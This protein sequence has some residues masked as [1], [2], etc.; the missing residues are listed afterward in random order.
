MTDF[1]SHQKRSTRTFSDFSF[2]LPRVEKVDP[3]FPPREQCSLLLSMSLPAIILLIYGRSILVCR[4]V[5]R[6]SS[7]LPP[8]SAIFM[9]LISS[10]PP[11]PGDCSW[12]R[13]LLLA[14][15]LWTTQSEFFSLLIHCAAK[16]HKITHTGVGSRLVSNQRPSE[17][18]ETGLQ[19]GCLLFAYALQSFCRYEQT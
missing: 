14:S 5:L 10:P 3:L 16:T 15:F 1:T 18:E 11:P 6:I 4:S 9:R 7:E 2:P 19:R 8:P 13:S 17:P 12:F